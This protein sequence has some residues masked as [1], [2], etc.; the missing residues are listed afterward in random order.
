[1]PNKAIF[2]DR[3]GVLNVDFGHVHKYEDFQWVP[4]ALAAIVEAKRQ[5]FLVIVVTNQAG[6]AKGYYD[7]ATFFRLMDQVK[8]DVVNAGGLIDEVYFCPHHPEGNPPYRAV[9]EC[10]KPK[11]GMLLRAIN[12]HN[13]DPTRSFLIGDAD[14]DI[15]AATAAGIRSVKFTGGNILDVL[16]QVGALDTTFI[17]SQSLS[18]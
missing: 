17:D 12:E 6:I 5:G 9:C 4:G 10:R 8:A 2:F 15:Q 13:I 14:T 7:E 1:M 11:P 18:D 16:L 3:D